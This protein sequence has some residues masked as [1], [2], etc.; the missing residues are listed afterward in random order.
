MSTS[1]RRDWTKFTTGRASASP[2][3]ILRRHVRVCR[4]FCTGESKTAHDRIIRNAGGFDLHFSQAATPG[5]CIP[6]FSQKG[7]CTRGRQDWQSGH[8]QLPVFPHPPQTG[9]KSRSIPL[10]A[11]RQKRYDHGILFTNKNVLKF[12]E[13]SH[14]LQCRRCQDNDHNGGEH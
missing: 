8:H 6:Q 5:V 7:L 2:I 9:G 4:G 13:V 10:Q 14:D 1:T 11:N 12:L 3:P